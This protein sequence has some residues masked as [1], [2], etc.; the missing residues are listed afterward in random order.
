MSDLERHVASAFGAASGVRR[1]IAQWRGVP[2]G[3]ARTPMIVRLS[4]APNFTAIFVRCARAT[5]WA[6]S[7]NRPESARASNGYSPTMHSS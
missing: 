5:R 4:E 2:P 1:G 6:A 3:V 7:G